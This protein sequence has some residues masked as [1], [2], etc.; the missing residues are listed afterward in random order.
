MPASRGTAPTSARNSLKPRT[1]PTSR[2]ARSRY[3]SS[4]KKFRILLRCPEQLAHSRDDVV[5]SIQIADLLQI[6]RG[7]QPG[8]LEVA[9]SVDGHAA[10]VVGQHGDVGPIATSTSTVASPTSGSM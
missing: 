10:A 8:A 6:V 7:K 1:L 9:V 2:S 3:F 4:A 5:V